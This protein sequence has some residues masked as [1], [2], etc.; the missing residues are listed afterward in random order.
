MQ[1]TYDL[2]RESVSKLFKRKNN[3]TFCQFWVKHTKEE[4]ILLFEKRYLKKFL[5]FHKLYITGMTLEEMRVAKRFQEVSMELDDSAVDGSFGSF[6]RKH[7]CSCY[8]ENSKHVPKTDI[9][10]GNRTTPD[11]TDV[12]GL[13]H[14]DNTLIPSAEESAISNQPTKELPARSENTVIWDLPPL[15]LDIDLGPFV[16]DNCNG[17]IYISFEQPEP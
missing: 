1:K 16:I 13:V 10:I 15:D 5:R 8:N 14:K 2:I 7:Y 4:E 9:R 11:K 3:N 12:V 17:P 6:C